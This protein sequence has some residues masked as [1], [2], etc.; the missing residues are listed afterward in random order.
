MPTRISR[1]ITFK[2]GWAAQIQQ[3]PDILPKKIIVLLHGWTGDEY[4]MN[5]FV[6]NFSEDI[7]FVS[8]RGPIATTRGGYGWAPIDEGAFP[9]SQEFLPA[10]STLAKELNSWIVLNGFNPSNLNLIGFS[11]G[12][13][14]AYILS[15]KYKEMFEKTACLSGYLPAGLE[16]DLA[17]QLMIGKRYYISHGTLDETVPVLFARDSAKA[18]NLAGADVNYCEEN[19]GHK[20]SLPCFKGLEDFFHS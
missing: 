6:Q 11:Q 20:L 2:N 18:L 19:V 12:A 16:I 4:S 1:S 8:P 15:I 17:P 7:L 9:G 13:C 5:I 3:S 10:A 14:M